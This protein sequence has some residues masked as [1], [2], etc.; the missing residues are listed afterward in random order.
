MTA[1]L[2]SQEPMSGMLRG[3]LTADGLLAYGMLNA[4]L[5]AGL[6]ACLRSGPGEPAPLV[7]AT[8]A[9]SPPTQRGHTLSWLQ[10]A[11]HAVSLVFSGTVD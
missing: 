6:T 9:A 8:G 11:A 3:M 10:C 4:G 2:V 5:K 7:W 1:V